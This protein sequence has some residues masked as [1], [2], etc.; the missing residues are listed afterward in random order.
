[1][2]VLSKDEYSVVLDPIDSKAKNQLEIKELRKG[3]AAFFSIL[4]F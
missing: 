3:V 4:V 2:T 1:M